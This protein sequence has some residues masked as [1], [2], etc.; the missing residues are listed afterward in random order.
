[1]QQNMTGVFTVPCSQTSNLKGYLRVKA[2]NTYGLALAGAL[3]VGL[4][5]LANDF[6]ASGLGSSKYA[7]VCASNATP[8]K[9]TA[10]GVISLFGAVYAAASGKVASSGKIFLGWALDAAAADGDVI[11]VSRDWSTG[12]GLLPFD[13]TAPA[14]STSADAAQIA[15]D[16]YWPASAGIDGTKGAKLPAPAQG[17]SVRLIN[18]HATNALKIYSATGNI[19]GT[20]GTTAYSLAAGKVAIA[21]SDG[22]NWRVMLSA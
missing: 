12:G 5:V 3:D 11:R 7:A 8:A 14:V 2:D 20:A 15:G 10:N 16:I 22:T 1:M 13:T 21:T 18:D 6:I 17:L 9:Y 4:G 19:N